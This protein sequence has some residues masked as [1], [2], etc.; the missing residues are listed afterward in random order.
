MQVSAPAMITT[1]IVS[2]V[3]YKFWV[4][5]FMEKS[6][7]SWKM[8]RGLPLDSFSTILGWLAIK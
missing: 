8:I 7:F 6:L 1:R 4:V 3:Y 2:V 5:N